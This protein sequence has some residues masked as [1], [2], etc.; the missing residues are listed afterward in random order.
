[1]VRSLHDCAAGRGRGVTSRWKFDCL[2]RAFI[3]KSMNLSE[4]LAATAALLLKSARGAMQ[5]HNPA[6]TNATDKNGQIS[7][8]HGNTLIGTYGRP[9][10]RCSW[11]R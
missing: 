6:S 4:M 2:G 10:A 9:R 5:C 7:K 8:K 3:D 1:M 11:H